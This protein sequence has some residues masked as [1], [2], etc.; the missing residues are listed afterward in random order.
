MIIG[1]MFEGDNN[2]TLKV[3]QSRE[4]MNLVGGLLRASVEFHMNDYINIWQRPFFLQKIKNLKGFDHRVLQQSHDLIAASF[5]YLF[6]T[7]NEVNEYPSDLDYDYFLLEAW[8]SYFNLEIRNISRN[9][10]IS[11]AIALAVYYQNTK[12]GYEA[13][14]KLNSLLL[15]RYPYLNTQFCYVAMELKRKKNYDQ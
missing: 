15:E 1:Y 13:E 10:E 14:D 8:K 4:Y 12:S 5:R 6:V 11:T 2:E 7:R 3:I 9:R